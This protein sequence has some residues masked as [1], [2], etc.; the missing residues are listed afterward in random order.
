MLERN[1]GFAG[2]QRCQFV[3]VFFAAEINAEC[4]AKG[5]L[6]PGFSSPLTQRTNHSYL[7]NGWKL[8]TKGTPGVWNALGI[9]LSL[10]MAILEDVQ[11]EPAYQ[12]L[13]ELAL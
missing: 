2:H 4:W 10:E 9:I 11:G 13:T 12:L 8:Q 7:M 3:V 5:F 6:W 1:L